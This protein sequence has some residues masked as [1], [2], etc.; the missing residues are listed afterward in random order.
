MGWPVCVRF[1]DGDDGRGC[2]GVVAV[3]VGVG[4][5]DV[6]LVV[7]GDVDGIDRWNGYCFVSLVFDKWFFPGN[8]VPFI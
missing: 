1:G 2:F 8:V 3:Y 7:I 6:D 4:C 5:I